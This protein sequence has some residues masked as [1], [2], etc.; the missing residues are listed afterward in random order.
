MNVALGSSPTNIGLQLLSTITARD[1]G[2]VGHMECLELIERIF[3]TLMKIERFNGHFFNWIDLNSIEP[4]TPRYVSQV[5]SGNLAADLL[6][7]KQAM[8]ETSD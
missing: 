7:L 6:V 2:F 1:L 5:D 3:A 8:I 4:L